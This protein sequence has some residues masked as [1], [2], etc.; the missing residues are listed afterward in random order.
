MHTVII[1]NNREA[2]IMRE[3]GGKLAEIMEKLEKNLKPGASTFDLDK[4]AEKLVFSI[5]GKPAFKGYNSG[6]S[7]PFPTTLCTSLN[8]EVVHGTPRKDKIINDGDI[9]KIDIGM[10]YKEF[11]VDMARSYAVGDISE[12]AQK[13]IAVT[14]QSFWEGIKNLKAEKFLSDYSKA[15]QK[16]VERRGF[17]VVRN[18]VGHGIGQELHEDPQIPNFYNKK[19]QDVKLAAGMTLALEPMVN[20]G[21]FETVLG[22]DGWVFVTRDGSLSAHY[23]NTV[24][25]TEK[26]VEILT[27]P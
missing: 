20:A 25:I 13:L 15:V 19:Y 7:R 18:L 6:F 11:Y 17:S 3:G 5:G 4:L 14:E 2:A 26:G 16:Y 23:E 12:K 24:V 10:K 8:D 22:K 27:I 9:L 1:K 21:S